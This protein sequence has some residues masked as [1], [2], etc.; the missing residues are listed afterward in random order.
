MRLFGTSCGSRSAIARIRTISSSTRAAIL[1]V[2]RWRSCFRLTARFADN[3]LRPD[4]PGAGADHL[5]APQDYLRA[6]LREAA[7]H[8]LAQADITEEEKQLANKALE[9]LRR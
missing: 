4:E 6:R 2:Q 8:L 1:I 3:G 7:K 5:H 9:G